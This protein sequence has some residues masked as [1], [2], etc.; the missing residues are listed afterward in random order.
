MTCVFCRNMFTYDGINNVY[1]SVDGKE[2]IMTQELK[3]KINELH[4]SGLGYRRIAKAL[5]IPVG[6]VNTYFARLRHPVK[7][8]D[9]FCKHCGLKLKQRRG[10]RQKIFCDDACR[11][12]W[13]KEHPEESTKR[14]SAFYPMKCQFCGKK[15]M[16]YGN[17]HRTFCSR[18]CYLKSIRGE[19]KPQREE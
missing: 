4:N 13:W 6:T 8:P 1:P 19:K 14:P 18:E 11:R 15:Y 2:T 17:N 12:A 9:T 3:D 7:K 5:N 16:S 10:H